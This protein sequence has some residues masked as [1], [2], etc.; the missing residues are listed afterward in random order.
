MPFP[1]VT[2]TNFIFNFLTDS[3][4]NSLT[5]GL[6]KKFIKEEKETIFDP[7]KDEIK[8]A[9]VKDIAKKVFA[10]KIFKEKV[11][12]IRKAPLIFFEEDKDTKGLFGNTTFFSNIKEGDYSNYFY[13]NL[14]QLFSELML[15]IDLKT[16]KALSPSNPLII[17]NSSNAEIMRLEST[18][19]LKFD[20]KGLD[21]KVLIDLNKTIN[22]FDINNVDTCH[23]I[24]SVLLRV[25]NWSD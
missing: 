13:F 9:Q 10:N 18:G 15:E 12:E 17:K 11:D 8:S 3:S 24:Q 22:F 25:K 23:Y 7:I 14:I 16:V 6:M 19:N 20:L 4:I 1:L 21:E 2:E 5:L